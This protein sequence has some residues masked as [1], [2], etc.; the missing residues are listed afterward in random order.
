M[1]SPLPS[2]WVRTTSRIAPFSIE[3]VGWIALTPDVESHAFAQ[4]PRS[5][6]ADRAQEVGAARVP[7]G[8]GPKVARD[9]RAER[10]LAH[11]ERQLLEAR[12]ALR[13]R[14]PVEVRER[15]DRVGDL[16]RAST[17]LR[18]IATAKPPN[19]Y[20]AQAA[21]KVAE[22]ARTTDETAGLQPPQ[23]FGQDVGGNALG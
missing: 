2:V 16:G 17:E 13:V 21:F 15:V 8:V 19:A 23:P 3:T 6:P 12:G 4:G 22:I 9:A 18:A 20:S 10:V 1:R 7:V 11:E 5:C 14:D